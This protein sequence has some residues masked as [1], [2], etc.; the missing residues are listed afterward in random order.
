MKKSLILT[1]RLLVMIFLVILSQFFIPAVREFFQGSFL[2]LLPAII[3]SLLGIV[4]IFLTLKE[5]LE[6]K[7][8]KFLILTGASAAGFFIFVLL[9]NLFYALGTITSHI[10]VLNYLIGSLHVAFFI[11]AVPVCP[12]GFLIG[13]AGTIFLLVRK[14][15]NYN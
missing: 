13:A 1:F 10:P 8:K 5:K 3:F 9:H 7:L 14:N 4:L 15:I 12:L 11:L 6:G 2:F